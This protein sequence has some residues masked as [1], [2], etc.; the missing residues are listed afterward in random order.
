LDQAGRAVEQRGA[1]ALI[2]L[3]ARGQPI[4]IYVYQAGLAHLALAQ[5]LPYVALNRFFRLGSSGLAAALTGWLF[6]GWI[7]RHRRLTPLAYLAW[8]AAFYS[9]YWARRSG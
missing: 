6:R 5:V 2:Q 4:K 9:I 8:W 3:P 1:A 7:Q